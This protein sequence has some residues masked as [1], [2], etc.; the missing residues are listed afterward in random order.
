MQTKWVFVFRKNPLGS[1]FIGARLPRYVFRNI[2]I[3]QVN[4]P[5]G[6]KEEVEK[7][8]RKGEGKKMGRKREKKSGRM[9]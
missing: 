4:L 9:T 2:K 8:G 3:P 1:M 7:R 6:M 5:M